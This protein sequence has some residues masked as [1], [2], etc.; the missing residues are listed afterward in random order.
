MR[1]KC[2]TDVNTYAAMEAAETGEVIYGSF[3]TVDDLMEVLNA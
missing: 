2:T 1:I 3:D